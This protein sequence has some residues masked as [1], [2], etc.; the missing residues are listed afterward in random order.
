MHKESNGQVCYPLHMNNLPEYFYQKAD[1]ELNETTKTREV[2]LKKLKD[3]LSADKLATSIEFEDDFLHQFLR[4]RKYDSLRAL[5][6]LQK[7]L[8]FRRS[9][10]SMFESIPEEDFERN[11]ATE[12][13]SVLP[14]R[15]PEGCVIMICQIHHLPSQSRRLIESFSKIPNTN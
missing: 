3:L 7:Y 12:C 14:C 2:E 8:N 6:Y 5:Q 4:H 1:K 15:C 10:S 11:P 13:F 9:H